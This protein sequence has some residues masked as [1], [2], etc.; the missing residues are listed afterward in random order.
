[1]RSSARFFIVSLGAAAAL[2]VALY[3]LQRPKPGVAVDQLV[4]YCAAGLKPPVEEVARA[5]EQAGGPRVELQYGGSGALLSNLRVAA[6]GDLFIAADESYLEIARSNHLVA[7]VIPLA[8]MTPVI[9]VRQGNPKHI[10]SLKDLLRDDVKVALA[11]PEAAAIG[12]TTRAL[13]QSAGLWDPVSAHVVVLKPTVNDLANDLKLGTADASILWDAVVNQYPELEAVSVPAGPAHAQQVAVGVLTASEQPTA[14]LRFA[15]YLGARD[16][17]LK[18]F[19]KDGYPPVVGDVWAEIPKVVL[20]SGGVNRI[21]IDETVN[22]FEAREGVQVTRVYN[23]CGILVAQIKSGQ[24]PDAY[25]A[26]DVTFLDQVNNLFGPSTELSE[27]DIVLLVP[28]GNPKGLHTL[29]DLTAPGLKL[30]V[31]NAQQSTLGDLTAR[32][33]RAQGIYDGVMANVRVQT[34]TAD[35]L[36]NDLRTGSLD[37]VV[38]YEANTSQVR[39]SLEVIHLDLP[40][41][42]AIQPYA[43]GQ[44]SE[45]P[46]LMERLLSAIRTPESQQRYGDVGFRWLDR[47]GTVPTPNTP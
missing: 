44:S 45:Y 17:G 29:S 13:L 14:A 10:Q 27:T 28:K 2:G 47:P 40:G 41:A 21:A 36:V 9:G 15:R 11:N 23:G 26:C 39:D 43:V 33:L 18:V 35:L 37:A 19:E 30:G 34:P 5:Y 16:R 20:Y 25:L 31:A 22:R 46:R 12:R 32:L 42:K 7:E 6:R 24:R 4:V 38:V 8:R 1:M 3:L